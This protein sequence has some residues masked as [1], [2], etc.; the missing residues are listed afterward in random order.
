MTRRNWRVHHPELPDAG[1]GRIELSAEESHHVQR[2]LRLRPGDP[3][4]VFDGQGHEW[5]A[6]IEA[7]ARGS[8]RVRLESPLDNRVEPEL[9]LVLCQALCPPARMEWLI[10]KVTEVGVSAVVVF[11]AARS[12]SSSAT[13]RLLGRWR[14]IALEAAKQS[15]RT[16]V[17][18]I[19]SCARLPSPPAERGLGLLL[20]PAEDVPPIGGL[21]PPS[22]PR[23]VWLAVGPEGGFELR[24]IELLTGEGW[25]RARLGPRTLR[26]DTA[27]LVAAAI[28]LHRWG[29][30]GPGAAV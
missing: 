12:G 6:V 29:D 9:E 2:V 7:A 25:Q 19:E 23:A 18:R 4:T 28:L 16:R 14:R 13:P 20:D 5:S 10:Q 3:L 11:G 27:G 21:L 8:V 17:P 26:A 30:L 15:G 1:G 22:P 24:E